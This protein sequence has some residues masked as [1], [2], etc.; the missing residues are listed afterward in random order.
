MK[1]FVTIRMTK[2]FRRGSALL[3]A[4]VLTIALFIMGLAFVSTT[5]IE[6]DTVKHVDE[7]QTLDTAVDTVIG[8]I[9]N[10]LVDD[11]IYNDPALGD[12]MLDGQGDSQG[13]TEKN[14]YYDYPGPDDPWLAS[15]EPEFY[16]DGTDQ[17]YYWRHITDLYCNNFAINTNAYYFDPDDEAITDQ[18]DSTKTLSQWFWVCSVHGP[19]P[20]SLPT[21]ARIVD[22]ENGTECIKDHADT[23]A[24]PDI[25]LWGARADA[26]GDGVADS[27]WVKV[28][29]LTGPRGQNVYTAVRIIDNGGMININTANKFDTSNS[30]G[31]R[32][33]DI[34]LLNVTKDGSTPEEAVD[35]LNDIRCG[36][37]GTG[38]GLNP[39][40][41]DEKVAVRLQNPDPTLVPSVLQFDI[42]DELELRNRGFIDSYTVSRLENIWQQ[43]YLPGHPNHLRTPYDDNTDL[44][45]WYTKA[46]DGSSGHY[47]R[48]HICTTYSFDRVIVPKPNNWDTD[49]PAD[50]KT[51]WESWT[52][53]NDTDN[54]KWS[55]R[56]VCVN[57]YD[58]SATDPCAVTIEQ[59][60]AAIWLGLPKNADLITNSQMLELSWTGLDER[61]RL[62]C[63]L[64]VNMIDYIDNDADI[65]KLTVDIDD[66][67]TDE[68]FYG[69]ES[70]WGNVF[71]T[72]VGVTKF[73]PGPDL[74]PLNGDDIV[75]HYAIVLHNPGP[76][77]VSLDGWTVYNQ[78]QSATYVI[79]DGSTVAEDGGVFVLIDVEASVQG[80]QASDFSNVA[81]ATGGLAFSDDEVLVLLDNQGRPSD[82]V[83]V[84][85]MGVANPVAVDTREVWYS[86]D[87]AGV[88]YI[89]FDPGKI[90]VWA[91][92]LLTWIG[93]VVGAAG[94]M[95]TPSTLP[96]AKV[97]ADIQTDTLASGE[98]ENVAELH[99]SLMIG[100]MK[101]SSDYVTMSEC[102]DKFIQADAATDISA[103][104]IHKGRP[105]AADPC[106]VNLTRFL[107][108]FNPFSDDI[109]NDGNGLSD[110]PLKDKV[111]NDRDGSTDEAD[112]TF[113]NF[114]EKSEL[115]IAG[116]ININT[117]PW[118]VIAQLPWV[119]D[120][121]LPLTGNGSEH[122]YKLA[123]A[124]VA[125]RDLAKVPN[126]EI[127]YSRQNSHSD[128]SN[129][130]ALDTVNNPYKSRKFAMGLEHTDDD[131]SREDP[132][133]ASIT[134]LINVTHNL[135][136]L[137]L[138]LITY[139][140]HYDIRRYGRDDNAGVPKNNNES[141][142]HDPV[143]GPFLNDNDDAAN[144]L[145]ERDIIFQR[146]SNLVTVRSDVF[147]AYIMVRVGE[148]GP[149]K[150][151]IAIF[152]RS[153]V[154]KSD[155]TPKLVALHPVP[156]PR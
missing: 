16:D 95:E 19:P 34:N 143:I 29:N 130:T 124:I 155:D 24:E 152:D 7:L 97:T 4:L 148:L 41:Y 110:D 42:S 54:K 62:A 68:E 120:P 40:D 106:F 126:T 45:I 118:F 121:T 39:T 66:D 50:L 116:R 89:G 12:E 57:D 9:N 20:Q 67:G 150:R 127:D 14:E 134:E 43:T 46:S 53:W 64:A 25:W 111:D 48:R 2:S 144:D 107:T 100:A 37:D 38:T 70:Q 109:D 31:S 36:G 131:I 30:D 146:I 92:D 28:P 112:E 49:M 102:W 10:V 80:F 59:I 44:P 149:Q 139:D 77:P 91:N 26:D 85:N 103:E 32:L 5:Q 147:T 79:P 47:T 17:F 58:P 27:R 119:V 135:K 128:W 15:L 125:Y 69:Y 75:P 101:F 11:L 90:Y 153:N 13:N 132:G 82:K 96:A 104:D 138:G 88:K 141:G 93:P 61:D 151:V 3:L 81:V 56:P 140:E 74:A 99:K 87:R 83:T 72:R 22:D 154:Y 8:R 113:A 51:A 129:W 108:V 18:W 133:F 94:V 156:D 105:D 73:D 21:V 123:Q 6:K 136:A 98:I 33:T 1:F 117:A 35:Y 60:A 63:Q 65:T 137:S 23:S 76:S 84:K 78:N 52:D 115:A 71:I 55:Y 122:R 86:A 114:G 142:N 145:K